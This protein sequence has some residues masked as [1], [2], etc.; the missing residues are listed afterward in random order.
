MTF[1]PK[2]FKFKTIMKLKCISAP[3]NKMFKVGH[4]YPMKDGGYVDLAK[5]VDSLG[6]ERVICLRTLRFSVLPM[7][8]MKEPTKECY[9]RFEIVNG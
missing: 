4:Q 5:T 1:N 2:L 3:E 6:H 7:D 9:A 8:R